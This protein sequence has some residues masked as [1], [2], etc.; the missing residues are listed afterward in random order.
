MT[1]QSPANT[2]LCYAIFQIPHLL[3]KQ[4]IV[5]KIITTA[6]AAMLLC[7]FIACD[8]HKVNAKTNP[9]IKEITLENMSKQGTVDNN[10]NTGEFKND[11]FAAT[12][13]DSVA[14]PDQKQNSEKDVK[15]RPKQSQS[16]SDWDKKIIKTASLNFEAAN[17]K[18]FN[19]SIREKVK[20]SGGYIAQEEQ[21]QTDYKIENVV[22][23]KIPVDQFDNFI[24]GLSETGGK[25][26]EKKITSEDVTAEF[27]D[28]KS[29]MEAKKQVRLRYLD[30]LKQAKNMDEILNVQNEINSIQEE[31][32]AASGRVNYLS[33]SS[34]FST[35]NLTFYQ[36][37]NAAAK[38]N[39]ESTFL[40]KV[41][42]SFKTGLQWI[43]DLVIGIISIWPL[44][45]AAAFFWFAF[46]K[47]FHHSSKAKA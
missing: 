10:K 20:I 6:M 16:N 21:T 39:A 26:N 33:H 46:K 34:A 12:E 35:I 1:I 22:V 40:T 44:L 37:L 25:L 31:I 29:R 7:T 18:S 28:T 27:V 15:K 13:S 32:E 5:M 14:I 41:S 11:L 38:D 42:A 47:W 2:G 23:I 4:K 8:N 19:Q 9:A 24:A 43:G 30:L 36:V 45:I 17:Y 3:T